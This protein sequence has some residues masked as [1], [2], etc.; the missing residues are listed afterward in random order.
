PGLW[1]GARRRGRD[2]PLAAAGAR[3]FLLGFDDVADVLAPVAEREPVPDGP[4]RPVPLQRLC[5]LRWNLHLAR[6]LVVLDHDIED[7]ARSGPC[8]GHY[9]LGHAQHHDS[10]HLHDGAAVRNAVEARLPRDA[11]PATERG[12]D[13][14]WHLHQVPAGST[15]RRP[16]P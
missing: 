15:A 2:G 14:V 11:A 9:R 8:L 16:E 3:L 1:G 7:V 13:L 4:G 12:H 10:A 5:E 6:G